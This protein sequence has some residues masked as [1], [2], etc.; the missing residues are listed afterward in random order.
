MTA[1]STFRD[2]QLRPVA[3]LGNRTGAPARLSRWR[4]RKAGVRALA[5]FQADVRRRDR[6]SGSTSGRASFRF[7]VSSDT[8][9]M[10][11]GGVCWLDYNNDG[12]LDLFVVN[13][14]A[15]ARRPHWEAHGG[16]PTSALFRNV[17]GKFVDV[18]S[19]AHAGLPVR[20]N[21]CVAADLNGDGYTDLFVTTAT[22]DEL[23][24]NNGNG[25]FTEGDAV[26]G[27]RLVRLALRRGGRGRERR[28]PARPLRRRL[29]EH[30]TRRSTGSL[31]G[32]P[33]NHHG[34]RDE[35]FLN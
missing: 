17:H 18:T 10:M 31:A 9:A 24:W 26:V 19:A 30:R 2:V 33:T 27:R 1:S 23:L 32:F 12:W 29:H 14:Y 25:T 35:L 20:G 4:S 15:D 8:P 5:G 34:V 21:G 13:S 6:R 28:R 7:G 22:D 11:G 3:P 16:L